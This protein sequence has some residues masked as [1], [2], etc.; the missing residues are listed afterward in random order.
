MYQLSSPQLLLYKNSL[1][2]NTE[3]SF[4]IIIKQECRKY[5]QHKAYRGVSRGRRKI[6][7]WCFEN[8]AH[9]GRGGIWKFDHKN[10]IKPKN[11]GSPHAHPID[12]LATSYT[13]LK[14]IFPKPRFLTSVHLWLIYWR[15][16]LC[17]CIRNSGERLF[18]VLCFLIRREL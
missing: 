13:P 5:F 2:I 15:R 10:A 12:F 4:R 1:P 8:I 17:P 3:K 9:R 14:R 11:S 18:K 16:Q 7:Q 6:F